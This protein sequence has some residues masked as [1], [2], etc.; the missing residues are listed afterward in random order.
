M[1]EWK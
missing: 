1:N